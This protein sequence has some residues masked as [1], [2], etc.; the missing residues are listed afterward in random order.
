MLVVEELGVVL[1]GGSVQDLEGTLNTIGEGSAWVLRGV[2]VEVALEASAELGLGDEAGVDAQEDDRGPESLE[3]GTILAD[4]HVL[5]SLGDGVS[6]AEEGNALGEGEGAHLR[7]EEKGLLGLAL[8]EQREEGAQSRNGADD[9]DLELIPEDLKVSGASSESVVGLQI[10]GGVHDEV[11]KTLWKRLLGLRDGACVSVE[12][13]DIELGGD[14]LA[15]QSLGGESLKA[16]SSGVA[17]GCDDDV[18]CAGEELLSDCETNTA[19]RASD[20]V[21]RHD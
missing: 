21:R 1:S 12:V 4:D 11:V 5:G 16:F 7:G 2:L 14:E 17:S 13:G 6:V 19:R 18:I 10:N 3:S 15:R 9:V 8:V 20:E